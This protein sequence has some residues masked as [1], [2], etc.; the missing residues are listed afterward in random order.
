MFEKYSKENK[1]IEM[2]KKNLHE[3]INMFNDQLKKLP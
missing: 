3:F 1:Y 2:K